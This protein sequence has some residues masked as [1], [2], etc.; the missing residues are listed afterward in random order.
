MG[1]GGGNGEGRGWL[2]IVEDK[3]R[4]YSTEGRG[5]GDQGVE[6]GVGA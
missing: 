5:W 3:R 4:G 6:G 1:E 2:N